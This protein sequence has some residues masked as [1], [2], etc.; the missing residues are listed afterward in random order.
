[1]VQLAN[2]QFFLF[3]FFV[4]LINHGYSQNLLENPISIKVQ[5]EK[6]SNVLKMIA[7]QSNVSFS[8]N[9]ANIEDKSIAFQSNKQPL[10]IVL[11]QILPQNISYKVKGKY[12]ILEK[13]S[14]QKNK[15]PK[16]FVLAG[17]IVDSRSGKRVE[18]VSIYEK[19]TFVSSISNQFGYYEMRL[20]THPEIFTIHIQKTG[21]QKEEI[22]INTQKKAG[23]VNIALTLNLVEKPLKNNTSDF[24]FLPIPDTL[25]IQTIPDSLNKTT[26]SLRYRLFKTKSTVLVKT[27]QF[28]TS[29]IQEIHLRN[30]DT[31]LSKKFQVSLL[32][33]VSTNLFLGGNTVTKYS[34]NILV[35]YNEGVKRFELGGIMNL[36]AKD[37]GYA[38][39]GGVGNI[40]G[41][42]VYGI[43]IGGAFNRVGQDVKGIQI[44]GLFNF[45]SN[46]LQG[47]QTSSATNWTRKNAFGGQIGGLLNRTRNLDGVQVSGAINIAA[48]NVNGVQVGG[49]GNITSQNIKGV[50]VSSTFNWVSK[51][52]TGVQVSSFLNYA[53]EIKEGIQV[54]GFLNITKKAERAVQLGIINIATDSTKNF[55]PIGLLSLVKNGYKRLEAGIDEMSNY[56]LSFKS[57]VPQFYNILI[58]GANSRSNYKNILGGYGIGSSVSVTKRLNSDFQISASQIVNP[59]KEI[60]LQNVQIKLSANAEYHFFKHWS[61]FGGASLNIWISENQN[62]F[63]EFYPK[64][65]TTLIKENIQNDVYKAT[66]IGFQGGLR[67]G[68]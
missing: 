32:P 1:M 30:L 53:K 37:V 11:N 34:F 21:Y 13:T 44:G 58:L 29:T 22:K 47:F 57:G 35:G 2:K 23:L 9:P 52:I 17:Y 27:S 65:P 10:R 33:A 48:G 67:L 19:T 25:N 38:Q 60:W 24:T 68:W 36:N 14:S 55:V 5:D 63:L 64:R 6:L 45:I 7:V 15:K 4:L 66:W 46:N 3:I 43:Q 50:Q 40:V 41:G 8:Y 39:I 18:G 49:F 54:S 26:P 16:Y 42:N 20:P 28:F 56:T 62:D 61:V 51:N 59:E 12:L 31:T